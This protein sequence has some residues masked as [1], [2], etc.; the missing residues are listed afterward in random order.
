MTNCALCVS[1]K[2]Q[3]EGTAPYSV[4]CGDRLDELTK[5]TSI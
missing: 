3:L 4:L 1:V 2:I 5:E